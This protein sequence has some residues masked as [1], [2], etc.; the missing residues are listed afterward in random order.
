MKNNR[1]PIIIVKRTK[2]ITRPIFW[3]QRKFR[4]KL[5]GWS[6]YL[7]TAILLLAAVSAHAETAVVVTVIGQEVTDIK[8]MVSCPNEPGG[9][10]GV[11][12]EE[13]CGELNMTEGCTLYVYAI[14]KLTLDNAIR[15]LR[16][17][18][19]V[20]EGSNGR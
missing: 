17:V 8:C 7:I 15:N 5:F 14:T 3:K 11:P 10:P 18:A 13:P 4:F 19:G 9:F 1:W 2:I 16:G 20:E 12:V 6:F